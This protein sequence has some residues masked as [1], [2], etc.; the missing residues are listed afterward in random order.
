[1]ESSNRPDVGWTLF[2]FA[3]VVA[4]NEAPQK[5]LVTTC[6]RSPDMHAADRSSDIRAL[7]GRILA[8]TRSEALRDR[9]DLRESL[10]EGAR[11]LADY[12]ELEIAMSILRLVSLNDLQA[13]ATKSLRRALLGLTRR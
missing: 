12:G 7:A 3:A 11:G 5:A 9:P 1:M 2:S 10:L 4:S 13:Q 6:T 8:H